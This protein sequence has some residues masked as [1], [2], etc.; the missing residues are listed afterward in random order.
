MDYFELTHNLAYPS[1]STNIPNT[2][3]QKF[4]PCNGDTL[5][6]NGVKVWNYD[7]AYGS[8]VNLSIVDG[9][10]YEVNVTYDSS[11]LRLLATFLN[12]LAVIV[13]RREK[14]DD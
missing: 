11:R 7:G 2:F 3:F 8:H 9:S 5:S 4:P 1:D 13:E 10:A 6:G 14:L 12:D